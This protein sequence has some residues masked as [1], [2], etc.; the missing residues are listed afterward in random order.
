VKETEVNKTGRQQA[1]PLAVINELLRDDHSVLNFR[2]IL[3]EATRADVHQEFPHEDAHIDGDQC[4]GDG[5]RA[6]GS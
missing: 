6:C 4:V 5:I 2:E 1:V 3:T